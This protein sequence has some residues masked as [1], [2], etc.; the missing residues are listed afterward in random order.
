MLVG[1]HNPTFVPKLG[2]LGLQGGIR[3]DEECTNELLRGLPGTAQIFLATGY[4]NLTPKYTGLGFCAPLLCAP[5]VRRPQAHST[6]QSSGR[7]PWAVVPPC[8]FGSPCFF[9]A[10][11]DI[12]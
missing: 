9:C 1:A 2:Q 4:F 12:F 6:A 5:P 8:F 3:N 11:G 7:P 10:G